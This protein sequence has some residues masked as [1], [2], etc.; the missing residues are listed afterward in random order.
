[1]TKQ[2][3]FEMLT[4]WLLSDMAIILKEQYLSS[5]YWIV[6][7]ALTIE[8]VSQ[9]GRFCDTVQV[10]SGAGDMQLI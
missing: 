5:L 10:P 1:M 6:A 4:H 9:E 3:A 2:Q 7:W 8:T